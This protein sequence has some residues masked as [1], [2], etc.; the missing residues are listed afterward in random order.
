[1][2]NK[3]SLI[4]GSMPVWFIKDAKKKKKK[5]KELEIHREMTIG[6]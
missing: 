1:M 2:D 6:R 5:E 3:A 4:H